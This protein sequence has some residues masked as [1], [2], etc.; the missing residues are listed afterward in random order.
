MSRILGQTWNDL[1][2]NGIQD[3]GETT[4]A[5]VSV[6]LDLNNNQ[7]LDANE[8]NVI[9]DVNGQY[10]FNDLLT[11]VYTVR[12]I[13]P[14]GTSQVFPTQNTPSIPFQGLEENNQGIAA[15]ISDGSGAEPAK[16][17]HP[18]PPVE[19][20]GGVAYY[21]IASRDYV[22]SSSNAGIQASGAIAGFPNFT[23]ALAENG[24][25]ASD[26]TVKFGLASLGEDIEGQDWL[27]SGDTETRYYTGGSITFQL[28]DQDLIAASLP[29]LILQID[30]NEPLN[31]DDDKVSGWTDSFIPENKSTNS[32]SG[33]QQVAQALL[34]DIGNQGI[35]FVFN[36]VQPATQFDFI[37][38]GRGGAFFAAQFGQIELPA[39]FSIR[40][41]AYTVILDPNETIQN[42]DFGFNS[43]NNFDIFISLDSGN[44]GQIDKVTGI[45]T[46][47]PNDSTN[48]NPSFLDIAYD[49]SSLWGINNSS[50]YRINPETGARNFVGNTGFFVNSLGFDDKGNL[51]GAGNNTLYSIDT[52]T[53]Q[54]TVKAELPNINSSG[55]IAWNGTGFFIT[56]TS[57]VTDTLYFITTDGNVN[58]IGAIGFAN[59]FGLAYNDNQLFGYT[60]DGRQIQ[61]NTVTGAGS[62]PI[63]INGYGNGLISGAD[64]ITIINDDAPGVLAFSSPQFS[65]RE[66]GIVVAAITVN[67]T[68]GIN[69]V[70]SA[71]INLQDGT[72]TAPRDYNNT[73][74]VVSFADGEIS[75]TVTI[76]IVND[77]IPEADET[78]QLLLT[79]PTGGATIG[80]QNTATL[81]IVDSNAPL[82]TG[83]PQGAFGSNK[84]KITIVIAGENFSPKDQ[85]SL[86]DSNGTEKA[87]SKVYWVSQTEAWATFDLQGLTTGNYDVKVTNGQN[88][89]VSDDSFTVTDGAIGNLQIR[90]SYPSVGVATVTYTNVGQTD[91]IAPLLR[92]VPTNAQVTY[93]E[94][95]TVSATLRQLLNL[96]L[97]VNDNGPGGI[98]TPGESGEFS[99][100]YTP[101][102]NGLISFAVEQ[103]Q[104][105][106]V[107]NWETIKA[108]SRADYSFI[109]NAA[110]DAIWSNLTTALGTTAGQF[111]AVMAENANYLSQLGQGNTD[112]S[113]LFDFEWKQAANTL[114]NVSL[115]S[116]T[117]VVDTAPGLSLTFNRTFYQSI[118]ERYNLGSLGRGWASQWDLRATTDSQGNVVIRSVGDLQRVFEQQ[119]DGTYSEDGGATLTITN[120]EYRLKEANG[121]V[122]LFGSDGKLNSVE[123]TNG[124]RIT[125]EYTDSRLTKLLHTNGDSLTLDY[126][127]QGR[128]RQITDSTGQVTTYNYDEAGE[129]LR[130]VT[131]PEGTTTYTYDTGNIAAKKYSLLSVKSDLGYERIF[132]YDNQGRLSKE[133]SNGEVQS[134]TYSYDSVAGVTITDSTGA[135]QTI[136]LDDRGNGGQIR[137]VDNQNLLFRYD[138][139]GNLIGATLPNG[140][141]SGYSYDSNGN[142]TKQTNLLNQDVKFTY[143]SRFNQLASF[144]D[145][146]G[147]K[148]EYGYDDKGNLETI[149]YPDGTFQKFTVD[150]LG[151]IKTSVNRRGNEITY[152]YKPSGQLA[153]KTYPDGSN[154]TYDYDTKGNL[155]RII[156]AQGT[157][158][159]DYNAANQVEKITYP[160]GRSLTYSYNLDGQRTKLVSSDGY[161]VN[162]DY[163]AVGRLK[164]LKDAT[165]NNIITYDYDD[166]GRL[167]KE[168]NGNGTYTTY[169]YDSQGQLK[170]LINYKA[171]NTVNSRFEYGYDNLG[172]RT[173]MTTLE[174]TFQYG[175][176]AVGQLTS[177]ITPDNRTI[178]YEYDAAGNRVAVTDKGTTTNYTP[179]NLNQYTNVGNAVYTYDL[180]GN[181]TTKTQGGQTSTYT[182]DLENRLVKVETPQGTWEYE[183]DGLGNRVATIFNGQRTEYL[184]DPFGLGD[185]V[186]EYDGNGNLIANYTH[187]IG[188]VRRVNGSNRNYYDADALGSTVGLTGTDGSYVNRYSYLPFG[189]DLTKVEGVANPFEYVG[190]WGVMDEGNGLDF[191]RARFY[192]TGLGRFTSVDPLGIDAGDP[193]LYG[194]TFNNPVSYNDPSGLIAP[195]ALIGAGAAI[196]GISNAISYT[197]ASLTIGKNFSYRGL[198]GAAVAG[199]AFGAGATQIAASAAALSIT[200]AVAT[201]LYTG[202]GAATAA[203]GYVIE[204]GTGGTTPELISTVAI[205]AIG[206][207]IVPSVI[208]FKGLYNARFGN[209]PR[210]QFFRTFYG[211]NSSGRSLI[212]GLT[213]GNLFN[214]VVS[215]LLSKLGGT[216][217]DPHLETLDGLGYDFQAVGEFTLLKSTTD[218]FEIQTRQQ[219]WGNTTSV[220]IN[221]A[222]AIKLGDQR[223]TFYAN[224]A[225][226]LLVNGT[227]VNLPNGTL[228]AVGQNLITREG[229]R[230]SVI[231]ANNDF[232]RINNRGD[233]L[234]INLGLADNRQGKVV[235]LLGNYNNTQNDEFALRDGTAIGGTI[236]NEQ[237]YGDYAN[238]WRV[239]QETSLFDYA[240]GQNTNTFTDLTFPKNIITAATLTP[241]QRAAAE[242]IARDAGIT[243][244]DVLEDVILD[245]FIT[246][247]DPQFIQ[248]AITQQRLETVSAPNT[249]INPDGFGTQ[250]YLTASAVI[251]YIIRFTN[252]ADQ[253]TTPI[254]QVTITQ[255]LDT[256]LDLN[257][258]TLNDFGFG[259]ITVDVPVGVQNY[260][261][262]L[263]LRDARGVFVDVNAGLNTSTGVVTWTLTA[264]DPATNNPVDSATQGFLPPNDATN[265]GR[266]F[267]SYSIQPQANSAN[268]TRIDAQ[269]TITF[270]NQTP[271][272]TTAVFNTLDSDIPT[273]TVNVLPTNSN[274]NFTVSWTGS[275]NGSG[276][277]SYD[278]YVATDG[279][280]YVLWQEDTTETSA[281]YNGEEGKSYS[282]YSVA[283][284]NLGLIETA[285]T[286]RDATTTVTTTNTDTGTATD[287]I[288][289]KLTQGDVF[290]ITGVAGKA[291]LQATLTGRNSNLVNELGVF[292]VDDAQGKINGIAPGEAGYTQAALEKSKVIFSTIAN[293]P[294][295]F[296]INNLTSL[297]EFNSG[298]NLRFFL[299]KNST[300]D[301]V[302]NGITPITNILFS[303]FSN[304]KITDLGTDGFSLSWKDGSNNTDFK[305]LVVNIQS[306]NQSLPVGTNLQGR[307]QGEVIDLRGINQDVK[308]DFVVNREAAFNNFVGFYKVAD[309]N[310]GIDIDGN[311]TIDFRPGDSGYAQAAVQ[312]R[313][314]GIDLRVENQGTATFTDKLLTGDSVFAPFMLTNGRTVDQVLNGQ[315]DQ[316]YFAYLGANSDKVDHVRLLGNNTFG[317]EDLVGGGDNDFNDAII[318]A[319]LKF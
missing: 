131:S 259:D 169:E 122:S 92:I 219:P 218:D 31:L 316:I 243:D 132:E 220:S 20:G 205:G 35:R 142:L 224:Q 62:N 120:G 300:I 215:Q 163:D 283:T 146:K 48:V 298:D 180:D 235:G 251:P 112:L 233:F 81:T 94:D 123:D 15:W 293:V 159:L 197:I 115:I 98:L 84:G 95:D 193:N 6:Y 56:S 68:G 50:L 279:G 118:A 150:D 140:S 200:T 39:D 125:L 139:E 255:Q 206:G 188:L 222:I 141:Q 280:E 208:G 227:A 148:V 3:T 21:Y 124:N 288:K 178:N 36:S 174:G 284:D 314:A 24:Y 32:S 192:D 172:R 89:S 319:Q 108:E 107:I 290:T 88:T 51:Y 1:N 296:N 238:S 240:S 297:L 191:M 67:R 291:K 82:I 101:N 275:D 114:T 72:A 85:I 78:L 16:I 93:P 247:G 289:L 232:I 60:D 307:Q 156:S 49:G 210:I 96:N 27:F 241:E 195:L 42:L 153:Q 196:G 77:T 90:L 121:L 75:K 64:N 143:D 26:L 190:Q 138:N 231:T 28:K 147:N 58:Q 292:T 308:V 199:A 46:Q 244:P 79:N 201:G 74:I 100:S 54:A 226:P 155:D 83:L 318:Q 186:G 53:G 245:I 134:L 234:N 126:N 10:E 176:D 230:Y 165:E 170:F 211:K 272:Q 99:F 162:Y 166:A 207:R 11:G 160:N 261:Q 182:Y 262:R 313:V 189:E 175:Y 256:D 257:T 258:F 287:S 111:Q 133:Y 151:N 198:L 69:G 183:Y 30:Y 221:T 266:G 305:D 277:A 119:T 38:E 315:V 135:S 213:A 311:G 239:T 304:Q 109:D 286:Q 285:P 228:Y 103:V 265:A 130:S 310:G 144:T 116:T 263:D 18:L 246:N 317:F 271:I 203:L 127:T 260:S 37:Q 44:I 295:G 23:T 71:T 225:Q 70:V 73:P 302:R 129:N 12:L 136:L 267:V 294:N 217:N 76:P 179:N 253:G 137:G 270:N 249:L 269:A 181:L 65:V 33:V 40:D 177:V 306:T 4:Q 52:K 14:T 168:T 242:Q 8:P 61:I 248:G 102:G 202:L 309:E 164:S 194:Y 312:N 55:D 47:I 204:K 185:I 282:F 105:N 91:V 154:F 299:I 7:V 161:T 301:N 187:G 106:E 86:I 145:A 184:L 5:G 87:A 59:V 303:D 128:I 34:A 264:I 252:N 22:D 97:G 278:V 223:I 17:G 216:W 117:D 43:I 2:N 63:P 250:Q 80:Q 236:S 276:I 104:P 113:R 57:P 149:T 273:S 158:T 254:A 19:L 281:T 173:T 152:S 41:G 229:D 110:W 29:R 13:T 268:N 171:D 9:T 237:L 157:I 66:D 214:N 212:K 209:Q 274:P 25:S 45:F 167:K